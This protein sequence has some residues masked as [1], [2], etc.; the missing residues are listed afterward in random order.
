M[1]KLREK[2]CRIKEEWKKFISGVPVEEIDTSVVREPILR[3]WKRCRDNGVSPFLK[4]I[5]VVLQGGEIDELLECNEE[6]IRT[7]EPFLNNL[8]RSF[9]D[10]G[11]F[12]VLCDH[13]GYILKLVGD[14]STINDLKQG[15]FVIGALTSEDSVGTNGIGTALMEDTQVQVFAT[16]HYCESFHGYT[17]SGA[18]IHDERGNIIGMI[19]VAG[20]Y[21]EA[22]PHTLGMV[23]AAANAIENLLRL[24]RSFLECRLAENFQRMVISSIPE[25]LIVTDNKGTISLINQNAQRMLALDP[26]MAFG[27]NIRD[28]LGKKNE[29]FLTKIANHRSMTDEEVR[30]HNKDGS[31]ADYTLSFNLIT[32]PEKQVTGKIILLSEIA[33]A[34]TMIKKMTG[35]EAKISFSDIIGQ[36]P[37]FLETIRLARI[38]S[39][40]TSNVLLLGESGTGKDIFAQAIHNNSER[41]NGPYVVINCAAIPRNLI[42]SE[43]FGYDEGAFTGSKRGGNPGKFEIA[44]GGT[45]FLDEIGEMPLELQTTLLRIIENKEIMRVGGKKVR[46]VD[47]RI[48]A[49]TNRSLIDEVSNGNFREDLY[50]RLN[51]FTIR[52]PPLRDRRDDIPLLL[53]RFV[54]DISSNIGKPVTK[55]RD[56]VLR[57]LMDY[58]WPGNVRQLQNVLERAINIAPEDVLT[59]N[60]LPDEITRSP[61]V[62]PPARGN[63][64]DLKNIERQM[65]EGMIKSRASKSEIA[66][67]MNIS[68][69]TLYRKLERYGF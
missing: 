61:K 69:S 3:S 4:K 45:I 15:V 62:V 57:V 12:C 65:I 18:P 39:K 28:V 53:D 50:Y 19:D 29:G 47:V 17:C 30:I 6:L 33:R 52:I 68:R 48:L 9:S 60:L 13:R 43:L 41:K 36:N 64:Y 16:E 35:A 38:A 37:D 66:K 7:S 1:D 63:S 34:R 8:Y 21:L 27:K 22:N 31:Y 55:I 32:S 24:K 42:A 54:K 67:K 10:S 59:G 58:S 2:R 56:D 23:V 26:Q 44:D 46:S 51:V 14:E 5:P 11:F 49:A 20:P 25:A 40:S